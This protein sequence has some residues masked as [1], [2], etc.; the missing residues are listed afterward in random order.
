MADATPLIVPQGSY[1][2]TVALYRMPDGNI[3]AELTDMPDAV[4][5]D[6]QTIPARFEALAEWCFKGAFSLLKQAASFKG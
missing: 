1:L 5:E 2:A 4:I 6:R 3:R